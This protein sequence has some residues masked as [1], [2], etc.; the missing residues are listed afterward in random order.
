MLN[1]KVSTYAHLTMGLDAGMIY[2]TGGGFFV[3]IHE[4]VVRYF[5]DYIMK[6]KDGGHI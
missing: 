5:A 4:R 1:S 6:P 2:V 3:V